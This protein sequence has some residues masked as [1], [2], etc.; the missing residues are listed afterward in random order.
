MKEQSLAALFSMKDE[1]E[2]SEQGREFFCLCRQQEL[3]RFKLNLAQSVD[4]GEPI[5]AS[6]TS[7]PNVLEKEPKPTTRS[8][9]PT[10]GSPSSINLIAND[11]EDVEVLGSRS[12]DR[13]LNAWGMDPTTTL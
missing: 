7:L 2:M 9:P 4:E 6:R 5:R 12:E 10:I 3:V 1:H 11:E 13:P 8:T